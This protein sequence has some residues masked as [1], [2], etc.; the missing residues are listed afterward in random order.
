MDDLIAEFVKRD[1]D[2]SAKVVIERLEALSPGSLLSSVKDG[3]SFFTHLSLTTLLVSGIPNRLS[4][5]EKKL[6]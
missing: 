3:E 1:P 2:I 5:I 6:K 4:R